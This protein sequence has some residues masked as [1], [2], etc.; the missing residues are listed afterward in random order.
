MAK[1][2]VVLVEANERQ[3]M[4]MREALERDEIRIVGE[5][6]NGLTGLALL[7]ATDANVVVVGTN[8]PDMHCIDFVQ[9]FRYLQKEF[10]RQKTRLLLLTAGD[11]E[12]EIL[13]N[14]L[15]GADS[16]CMQNVEIERL[17]DAVRITKR[18]YSYIDAAIAATML[19][20]VEQATTQPMQLAVTFSDR[21][22][23]VLE[24]IAAGWGD[25]A[26]LLGRHFAIAQKLGLTADAV[27]ESLYS[28][29]EKFRA[30]WCDRVG[31]KSNFYTR[32]VSF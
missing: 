19:Q 4:G 23:A 17:V 7:E 2:Q 8:L 12:P 3:R 5:A 31:M 26:I 18:G 16:Y 32:S 6:A 13:A 22:L 29:F 11:R 24:L 1:I 14:L 21:E 25:V 28:I 15:A 20:Q 30:N 27:Q 9:R 10:D